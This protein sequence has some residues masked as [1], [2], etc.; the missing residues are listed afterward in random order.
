MGWL[1]GWSNR[2]QITVDSSRIDE[3]LTDFPLPI[4]LSALSGINAA[5]VSDLFTELGSSRKKI[6]LTLGDGT[7]QCYCEI[8]RWDEASNR[9]WLHVKVPSISSS[10]DTILYLYYD[11][12][13]TDNTNYVGDTGDAAAQ[14]VWD[15]NFVG[16]WHMGQD[17]SGGDGCILDSTSNEYNGTPQGTML[18][19]DLVGAQ[20]GKGIDF[21]GI[22]D[23]VRI[24]GYKGILG[25]AQRTVETIMQR[26]T[27]PSSPPDTQRLITWGVNDANGQKW[28]FR[29]NGTG[30]GE[31]TA[32]AVRAECH[33]GRKIFSSNVCDGTAHHLALT[34]AGTNITDTI[35]Y[36]DGAIDGESAHLSFTVNTVSGDDV[37][38]GRGFSITMEN[39]LR[40]LDECRISSIA[41]SA[42]WIKATYNGLFDSLLTFGSPE[43]VASTPF[44]SGWLNR[45]KLTIDSSKIDEDLSDFPLPVYLSVSSGLTLADVSGVFTELGSDANRKKIAITTSDGATQCYCEIER[46]DHANSKAWLHVKVPSIPSSTDTV[47]YLYY[48]S[49]QPDNASYIGDTGDAAAQAVW[50]SNFAG[51]W[52]MGQ[53]PDGGIDAVKDSTP[54]GNHYTGYNFGSNKLVDAKFGKG[55]QTSLTSYM[56]SKNLGSYTAVTA[57][58][59]VKPSDVSEGDTYSST[60]PRYLVSQRNANATNTAFMTR[61]LGTKLSLEFSDGSG[62]W[63][64]QNEATGSITGNIDNAIA[65]SFL[66]QGTARLFHNGAETN[67]NSLAVNMPSSSEKLVALITCDYQTQSRRYFQGI[68][69]EQR[70]SSIQ[71]SAAWIK[72]TYN[73]LFDS[74]LTFET[75]ES[76][77]GL[78]GVDNIVLDLSAFYRSLDDL[79]TYLGVSYQD[80]DDLQLYLG[81]IGDAKTDVILSLG[82]LALSVDDYQLFLQ[83]IKTNLQ[84]LKLYLTTV[85]P[86]VIEDNIALFLSVTDGVGGMDEEVR[87]YLSAIKKFRPKTGNIYQRLSSVVRAV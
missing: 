67:S 40:V 29:I 61:M 20:F 55:L 85:S 78:E 64:T 28:H 56:L 69:W 2:I 3:N 82:V 41:R 15:S 22:D 76:P 13:Q 26:N 1:S 73:G 51:V 70:V 60:N 65:M 79:G 36:V 6:A 31:G 48:D 50:D 14:A 39:A 66:N 74:L 17:P 38:L 52:H 18:S 59:Y 34:F 10:T 33:G 49:S 24:V 12:T 57:E 58:S 46:W 35:C 80:I 72:A 44:L 42:A 23:G 47:L 9:A 75:P 77:D 30:D 32:G 62:G 54:N 43:E 86:E 63:V 84:Y 83:A 8:E 11:S 68:I 87:L 7:T 81:L 21:D 71:R 5:D 45:I 53:D 37:N 25:T 16:V 27:V 4:Y 19:E